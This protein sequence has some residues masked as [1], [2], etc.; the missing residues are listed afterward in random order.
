MY[1]KDRLIGFNNSSISYDSNSYPTSFT[2]DGVTHTLTWTKGKLATYKNSIILAGKST[3]TY[4][5]D[6]Y[7]RRISKRYSFMKRSQSMASYVTMS[8]TDY[9]YDTSGRLIRENLTETYN[10]FTSVTRDILYL[11][12]ESGIVGAIQKYNS[13]TETFYFDRSIKGDVIGIY[14]Y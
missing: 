11:Y 12:D 6:G 3:Y 2:S 8:L 10:D 14:N 1:V 4:T 9:T 7:G 13:T 5:Y